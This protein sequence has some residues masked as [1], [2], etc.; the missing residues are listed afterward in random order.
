[1]HDQTYHLDKYYQAQI[2]S[3]LQLPDTK[4]SLRQ[5][6]ARKTHDTV[7][8]AYINPRSP[9]NITVNL[10]EC[11]WATRQEQIAA[12]CKKHFVTANP[13]ILIQRAVELIEKEDAHQ[14]LVFCLIPTGMYVDCMRDV[15]VLLR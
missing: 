4:Q 12:F 14:I 1:M 11:K 8:L 9:G 15:R 6:H 7:M 3:F 2:E 5:L 10:G 13:A